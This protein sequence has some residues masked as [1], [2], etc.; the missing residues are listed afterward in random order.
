MSSDL[1]S[2]SG[3]RLAV[4]RALLVLA[5]AVLGV[6][7]AHLSVFDQRGA[8]RGEAQ[9]LR[10]LTL[11]PERG[12]IVD[13]HGAGLALT[14]DA[15]S[16]YVVGRDVTDAVGVARLLSREFGT[17]RADVLAH[18][19]NRG[20]FRFV[21]R[22][23]T[24]AK[25]RAIEA[26]DLDGVG[27]IT[28]PR[29]IYPHKGLASRLV[30]FANIDGDGVR[31]IEQ[32]ED[33][34]LRG[35][36]RRLP[37][38]RDGS[39]QLLVQSGGA[40][41][42]T[43]GGDIALS[44][45][46]TLQAEAQRALREACETTGARGGLVLAMDPHTGEILS[47]AEWPTFDPNDFRHTK[48]RATRSAALLDAVEP[49]SAMK[50]FL[51]A[52]ALER[53]AIDPDEA[54]DT[55]SGELAL[56]GKIIRDARDFGPLD[57]AS[58]LRVSSNVG[59]VKIA[60]AL[61]R[62]PHFEMLRDFG[63]GQKTGSLFPDESAGVL[64]PWRDW[65]PVDHATI[66]FGQGVSVTPLQLAVATSVLANGGRL[67]RPRLVTAR[68]VAGG[69]WQP[70]RPEVVRQV[71]RPEVAARVL[72]MLETVTGSDGTGRRA[73]LP[74]IRTAGKT[75]TAQKWD[76]VALRYSQDAFRAW[77]VGIAPVDAPRVV[78]VTQ[79]DEPKRPLHSGGVAA[80]PLFAAVAPSQLAQ[81]GIHVSDAPP[82]VVASKTVE[83]NAPP[84]V[85]DAADT[86]EADAAA[87]ARA[88]SATEHVPASAERAPEALT[89]AVSAPPP[90]VDPPRPAAAPA[91]TEPEPPAPVTVAAVPAVPVEAF[92]DRVL[93]P[94]FV[95]LSRTEVMQ[96]TA[97]NG[98]SVKLQGDGVAVHQDPPPGSVVVAGSDVVR[99]EF[100]PA[101]AADRGN[102]TS[103]PR[104]ES[105]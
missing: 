58:V 13:R 12:R 5:F 33:D 6:R 38:E 36:T 23:T 87:L 80:A 53:D 30:G 28:E 93:L 26:A 74:G 86:P 64:R 52:A 4:A 32:Q 81:H 10:T 105:G 19:E 45:D 1:A 75:G 59:A 103:E 100:R 78:I 44:I 89:A 49:G 15:P 71:L 29:R 88:A 18:I 27:L 9:T 46:A 77:F 65:K 16:V 91:P 79:L 98:L 104:E 84:A 55:E 39:G 43:A 42:G 3:R 61:G 40:T 47:L 17:D 7:A 20:G 48:F 63:F 22:W 66:A 54:I 2:R 95:G 60:Q 14:I 83:A 82:V 50:A 31:G 56:P 37:V 90:T 21:A 41:W 57:P 24:D 102:A 51:V 11:A 96:V 25:A 34:W 69:S 67:L 94:D 85:D 68:R 99:I 70:T 97:A 76:A 35:T 101:S 72:G 8:E 73:A 62:K 92:R